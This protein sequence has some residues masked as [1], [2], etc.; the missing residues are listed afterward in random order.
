MFKVSNEQKGILDYI[1]NQKSIH[2]QESIHNN[3]KID[4]QAP[5]GSGKT[6]TILYLLE[7][8]TQNNKCLYLVFNTQMN[9]E[10]KQRLAFS[11]SSFDI[12]KDNLEQYTFHGFIRKELTK[13]LPNVGFD[14]LNGNLNDKHFNTLL[15]R[16]YLAISNY[17]NIQL[18]I[19]NFNNFI[20]PFV[21]DTKKLNDFLEEQNI[22]NINDDIYLICKDIL[23]NSSQTYQTNNKEQVVKEAYK[24]LLN[25][26]FNKDVL[27]DFMPHDIYYK[28]IDLHYGNLN[29][30]EN[31]DYVFV[32]E[33]QDIDKIITEL[34]KKSDVNL[35][36]LGDTFQQIN[37]F[38]GTVNSLGN[39][40]DIKTFFLSDSY[41]L[42]PYTALLTEAFLKQEGMRLGYDEKSIPKIYGSSKKEL[43]LRDTLVEELSNEKYFNLII[44]DIK[45]IDVYESETFLSA[46][47]HKKQIE[48]SIKEGKKTVF[49][50]DMKEFLKNK[51]YVKFYQSLCQNTNLYTEDEN[52]IT[53]LKNENDID[54]IK[55]LNKIARD[56]TFKLT[57]KEMREIISTENGTY[58]YFTRN[59]KKAID[60]VYNFVKKI[61]QEPLSE[62]ALFNINFTLSNADIYEAIKKNNFK[63]L[64]S[65]DKAMFI[66]QLNQIEA[67]NFK[68]MSI[69]DIKE[70][71]SRLKI[72]NEVLEKLVK[73]P[74]S[75][76]ILVDIKFIPFRKD[77]VNSYK[78]SLKDLGV[79]GL[80]LKNIIDN[81][82]KHIKTIKT[83]N[84]DNSPISANDCKEIA[85]L[86]SIDRFVPTD[87]LL[88]S[89]VDTDYFIGK[90]LS[91]VENFYKY[92]QIK[93]IVGNNPNIEL[94]SNGAFAN[95]TVS[96][97]H[98]S[99]GLEYDCIMLANDIYQQAD[100]KNEI[101][102]EKQ[103]EEFNLAYVGL[104]RTKGRIFLEKGGYLVEV[105][106]KIK[107]QNY[108][109]YYQSY[110]KN[111]LVCET[112]S[113]PN[114]ENRPTYDI[115]VN[116][117][118]DKI[119]RESIYPSE[120][121]PHPNIKKMA[122]E[123]DQNNHIKNIA[124]NTVSEYS[125]NIERLK[126]LNINSEDFNKIIENWEN[127]IKK[128]EIE[129]NN[130]L[131]NNEYGF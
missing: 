50:Q 84:C 114:N 113:N 129:L 92:C 117:G 86:I 22:T 67:K 25:D 73:E 10:M 17:A 81:A 121:L 64:S 53:N 128:N 20:N 87:K 8:L 131:K 102:L 40:K 127:E 44:E 13:K 65:Q 115:Y 80:T 19:D 100:D 21:K 11:T 46:S 52:S 59:N 95:F 23:D 41:R 60:T 57:K 124:N 54:L 45:K 62:V 90:K 103:K 97:I 101:D 66:R 28:Y 71:L 30:F 126:P 61:P 99:K 94:V 32:D 119:I 35:I 118:G 51:D 68:N 109:R 72:P 69:W 104:T 55:E 15:S 74:L 91:F 7:A 33:A 75:A 26:I 83:K 38:R 29:L 122:F 85:N 78:V 42:Q 12:N 93:E 82:I 105:L 3:I 98:Q 48:A 5:A 49:N 77:I 47:K 1:K 34:L 112:L 36:K 108:Q 2:N 70:H 96:T 58:G 24:L 63:A 4:V 79:D 89:Q 76:T 116:E 111:I 14:Y 123:L 6:T 31:Y 88:I 27:I 130:K 39:D 106:N 9:N 37:G 16:Y 56:Y 125:Q 110:N 120:D 107:E 18:L 43:P